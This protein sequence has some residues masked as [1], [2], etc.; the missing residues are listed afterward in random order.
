MSKLTLDNKT[1]GY[2]DDCQSHHDG[3]IV[4][5]KSLGQ[6]LT[7]KANDDKENSNRVNDACVEY[8]LS[9]LRL[10]GEVAEISLYTGGIYKEQ[11]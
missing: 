11:R 5:G 6:R 2:G 9:S 10:V 3:Q 8:Y 1:K 4:P 7:N